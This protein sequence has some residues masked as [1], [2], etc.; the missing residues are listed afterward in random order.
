MFN[1][2]TM[3]EKK[4][5][6]FVVLW[7]LMTIAD[8][9]FFS[10]KL[11]LLKSKNGML[12]MNRVLI[13]FYPAPHKHRRLRIDQKCPLQKFWIQILFHTFPVSKFD[14]ALSRRAKRT[15][16]FT[17]KVYITFSHP[18]SHF[19]FMLVSSLKNFT[20]L[21]IFTIKLY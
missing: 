12:K 7:Q 1:K 3:E 17:E 20:V 6:Y 11:S 14:A 21:K 8:T 2:L 13:T 16:S 15:K 19:L 5:P 10:R 18:T 9:T 4:F